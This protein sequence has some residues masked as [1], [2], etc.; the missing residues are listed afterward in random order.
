MD[1]DIKWVNDNMIEFTKYVY[2]KGYRTRRSLTR[3][4]V[5]KLRDLMENG[6]EHDI[7]IFIYNIA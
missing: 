6:N 2:G 4:E 7:D 5:D 1:R 3:R